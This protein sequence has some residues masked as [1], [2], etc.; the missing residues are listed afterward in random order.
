MR[1]NMKF[2]AGMISA[3]LLLVAPS[4][5]AATSAQRGYSQ[6][7]GT[8]QTQLNNG[9]GNQPG[10]ATQTTVVSTP[11]NAAAKGSSLPFTGLDLVLVV[12]AGGLLIGLGVG[13]RRLSRP[14]GIA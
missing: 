1:L 4:A 7:G 9:G 3:A 8:V 2:L 5:Y 11:E 6:P 10:A 12:A 14:T 13:I